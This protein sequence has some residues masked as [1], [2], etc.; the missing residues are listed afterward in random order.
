MTLDVGSKGLPFHRTRSASLPT[1][2]EPTRSSTPTRRAGVNVTASRAAS[3]H[4]LARVVEDFH[5][6][7]VHAS[8]DFVDRKARARHHPRL[9]VEVHADPM[10]RLQ[11]RLQRDR[12]AQLTLDVPQ[13]FFRP[14]SGNLNRFV[15]ERFFRCAGC[16]ICA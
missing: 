5:L 14:G 8:P 16:R 13:R 10:P 1:S 15:T 3:N 11:G 6:N 7:V 4:Q 12:N 2:S 9:A